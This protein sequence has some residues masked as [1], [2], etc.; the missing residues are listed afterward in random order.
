MLYDCYR[1]AIELLEF[2]RH[3]KVELAEQ[4]AEA[5]AE[6]VETR[7]ELKLLAAK[8]AELGG[9]IR[10]VLGELEVTREQLT[11]VRQQTDM[12]DAELDK[13]RQTLAAERSQRK[14]TQLALERS[15]NAAK[16]AE[17]TADRCNS[18]PNPSPEEVVHRFCSNSAG[19]HARLIAHETI[20]RAI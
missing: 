15:S 18:N 1:I 7:Q 3:E 20:E 5:Q 17:E 9:K 4:L 11:V 13:L 2:L 12:Q 19:G 16:L 10:G 6:G 14:Q 8:H